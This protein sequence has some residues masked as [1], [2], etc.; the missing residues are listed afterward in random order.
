MQRDEARL[1]QVHGTV[2]ERVKGVLTDVKRLV[3]HGEGFEPPEEVEEEAEEEEAESEEAE[4]ETEEEAAEVTKASGDE[5]ERKRPR[6]A[7]R[8]DGRF[9]QRRRSDSS[10]SWST[11]GREE[12]EDDEEDLE[13]NR[14]SRYVAL[15]E[16]LLQPVLGRRDKPGSSSSVDRRALAEEVVE[17][18][19]RRRQAD[20]CLV[21]AFQ[22]FPLMPNW[23]QAA[24]AALPHEPLD[25]EDRT[26]NQ[27]V[28][29]EREGRADEG[30]R[31]V[32]AAGCF[33]VVMMIRR[34]SVC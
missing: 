6:P 10:V 9:C 25:G 7:R 11:G 29:H 15:M 22:C 19:K 8:P 12:D 3:L 16:G 2:T 27:Q 28:G 30:R 5:V 1:A 33:V 20:G 31:V 13:Y 24:T 26:L 18:W 34:T 21:R 32:T 14:D 17:H 4:E 23:G